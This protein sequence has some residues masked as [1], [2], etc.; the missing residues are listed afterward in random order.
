MQILGLQ[1][2]YS[3]FLVCPKSGLISGT[4]SSF[5]QFLLL[6]LFPV[7]FTSFF[8]L[9][10]LRCDNS[11]LSIF[12]VAHCLSLFSSFQS[13]HFFLPLFWLLPHTQPLS[14]LPFSKIFLSLKCPPSLPSTPPLLLIFP[15]LPL[16]LLV[17]PAFPPL[18]SFLLWA[19][20]TSLLFSFL[21]SI[22]FALFCFY[23]LP[24]FFVLY[25]FFAVS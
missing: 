16:Y 23:L 24:C 7:C 3:G 14:C 11:L 5:K 4:H 18:V 20:L 1:S 13:L 19:F 25:L 6:C 17:F 15:S 2:C 9:P 12:Q 21:S 8:I 10:A 22:F